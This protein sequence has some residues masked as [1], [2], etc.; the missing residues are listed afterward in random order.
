MGDKE[1]CYRFQ[2]YDD[3]WCTL[4]TILENRNLVDHFSYLCNKLL[5]TG[6]AKV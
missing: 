6:E 4:N 2:N 5:L 3:S 1:E